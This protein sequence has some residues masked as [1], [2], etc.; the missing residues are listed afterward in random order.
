ME[1]MPP[2]VLGISARDFRATPKLTP[3][4]EEREAE[5]HAIGRAVDAARSGVGAGLLI[6]GPP[7]IGKTRLLG[8]ARGLPGVTVLSAR[9][10]ELERDFPFAVVR[11]LLEP[12]VTDAH[13][14]G[15]AAL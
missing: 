15:A 10:S 3:S 5:L 4:V 12:V 6:E 11:Q 7:G 8:V 2:S 9:A 13:F 14:T 1:F